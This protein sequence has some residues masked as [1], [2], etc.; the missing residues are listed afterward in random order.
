MNGA[1]KVLEQTELL[2]IEAYNFKS[3]PESLKFQDLIGL[4]ETKGFSPIDMVDLMIR[5]RDQALWQM[6]IFFVRST[7]EEFKSSQYE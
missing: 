7:R 4:M 3:G 6:D 5:K 1:K 2:I